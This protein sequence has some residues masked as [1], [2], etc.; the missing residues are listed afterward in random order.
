MKDL[1][2]KAVHISWEDAYRAEVEREKARQMRCRSIPPTQIEVMAGKLLTGFSKVKIW[3]PHL[4]SLTFNHRRRVSNQ[5]EKNS[6]SAQTVGLK[7]RSPSFLKRHPIRLGMAITVGITLLAFIKIISYSK[8]NERDLGHPAGQWKDTT[9]TSQ[10]YNSGREM[11][12]E[13]S[14]TH[15]IVPH[16]SSNNYQSAEA[17]DREKVLETV[18]GYSGNF[19][20]VDNS[21]VRDEP[22][23]D[24]TIIATLRPGTQVRV[25]SKT[26]DYLRVRS[27][28]D[29][30]VIGYVHEEDAFFQAR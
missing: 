18:H 6:L 14:K 15:F 11:M 22:E 28:S 24:A 26:G 23:P 27:L 20:V 13:S 7:D 25:E 19:E 30:D 8:Y 1:P 2:R 5:R 12:S 17:D 3:V 10:R 16:T 21:F 4:F 9:Q 29:A